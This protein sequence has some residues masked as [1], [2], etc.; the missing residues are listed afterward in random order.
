MPWTREQVQRHKLAA[1]AVADINHS[2]SQAVDNFTDSV[3]TLLTAIAQRDMDPAQI[4]RLAAILQR[5]ER[6]L[7]R[8]CTTLDAPARRPAAARS[9]GRSRSRAA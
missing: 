8:R 1:K 7:L 2:T 3:E 5:A 4:D 9:S 6:D